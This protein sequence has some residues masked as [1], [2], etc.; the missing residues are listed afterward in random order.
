V[1]REEREEEMRTI[2]FRAWDKEKKEMTDLREL[3]FDFLN[4]EFHHVEAMIGWGNRA[5]ETR[6]E[7]LLISDLGWRKQQVVLMQ[8]TGLKDKNGKEIYEGDICGHE[9][10]PSIFQVVFENGAFRKSYKEWDETLEKPVLIHYDIQLLKIEV[11]GNV[12]ENTEDLKR[13]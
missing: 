5:T 3:Y 4:G 6:K 1:Y 2:K 11:I 9:E 13:K 8:F 12:W 10:D 7:P